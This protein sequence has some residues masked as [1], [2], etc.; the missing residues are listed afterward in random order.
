MISG[1][2]GRSNKMQGY[3]EIWKNHDI[4][5]DLLVTHGSTRLLTATMI[6]PTFGFILPGPAWGELMDFTIT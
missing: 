5:V 6:D 1:K 3:P 2:S 4:A